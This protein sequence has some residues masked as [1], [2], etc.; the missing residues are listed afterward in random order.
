MLAGAVT[1]MALAAPS[2]A[3]ATNATAISAGAFHTCELTS[4]GAVKCWGANEQGQLGDGTARG[5]ATP[6]AVS[7]LSSGVTAISAGPGENSETTCALTSAGAV[8]CWGAN[9]Q[10]QLGNGTT[11]G[12]EPCHGVACSKTPVAVSGLSSGVIAISAGGYHTCALTSAGAVKCWG[13]NEEGQLGDGTT[14]RKTTPVAVSGLSSGVTAISAGEFDTCALTSAGAVD[15]WGYNY[16]GGL[17]D[18]TE[19]GKPTPV[20]VSGLSSGVTAISAGGDAT[21]A[22]TSAGAV[23]CWGYNYYGQLG[24]GTESNKT[25]P[26][27]VSGLSS[28]ITAISAS[29][30]WH[31]CALTSAGAVECW[32]SN[33]D[34]ELGDGT[35]SNQPTPVAVSGLSGGITAISAG[36]SHTCA[37]TSAGAVKC[38]GRNDGGQLG[39]GTTTG[40]ELCH[41]VAC[42]ETPVAVLGFYTAMCTTNTGTVKLSPGLSATPAVQTVKIKGTLS[43]CSGEAEAFR[44]AKYTATLKTATAVSCSVLKGPGETATGADTY[45]WTPKAKASTGTLRMLLTETPAVVFSGE[46]AIGSYSSL[47]FFGEATESYTGGP[48]CGEPIGNKAAKAVK[49]GTFSGSE[50]NF[51]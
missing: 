44:E 29:D 35:I 39:D 32:G 43:G 51:E 6:V 47:T 37:L 4:A 15:C 12:P 18:G 27:A 13:Y 30:G 8:K 3:L 45:K 19:T 22:L 11:T 9:E 20:A 41:G 40:P 16:Y 1:C 48:T 49:T 46:V 5:S 26:V 38:W 23:D 36:G 31:T 2:S 25:T 14:T 28:G 50:V 21:C 34:G 24:D 10:G 42:S 7:G 17:G 33:W